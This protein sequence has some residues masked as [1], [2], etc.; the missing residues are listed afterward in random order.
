MMKKSH[1]LSK[2]VAFSNFW[3]LRETNGYLANFP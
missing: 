3:A 2:F 1:G